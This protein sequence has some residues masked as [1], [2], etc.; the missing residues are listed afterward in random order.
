MKVE[1]E[2]ERGKVFDKF[3][4]ILLVSLKDIKRKNE[5]SNRCTEYI[6]TPVYISDQGIFYGGVMAWYGFILE[7]RND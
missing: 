2:R 3:V 5:I 6:C 1:R 7:S 4:G